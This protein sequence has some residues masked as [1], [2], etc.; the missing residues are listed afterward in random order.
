MS[1]KEKEISEL[2]QLYNAPFNKNGEY[3]KLFLASQTY[4]EGLDLK[5]VRHIHIFEP[6]I[7][8]ASDKQTIGRAARYCSHSDLNKKEWDVTIHRYIS[9]LPQVVNNPAAN[10]ANVDKINEIEDKI[11]EIDKITKSNKNAIKD[12]KAKIAANKKQLTKLK[13]NPGA[14]KS[15]ITLIQNE[16]EQY[17]NNLHMMDEEDEKNKQL[18]EAKNEL[19]NYL[20]NTKN[21]LSTKAEGAPPNFDEIKKEIDPVV[22]EGIKWLE[23]NPKLEVEDYKNKLKE[24]EDKIKPLITKLYGA[25]P[26]MGAEMFSGAGPPPFGTGDVPPNSGPG[27]VPVDENVD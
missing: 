24:Y 8:W 9:N 7:T 18:I 27:D 11:A 19:E 14:N 1:D 22:E 17:N 10:S 20:Y 15:E 26:P 12:N 13:K 2:R 6:L 23:E 25:V 3:V 4:N 5:A 21:S 16:V